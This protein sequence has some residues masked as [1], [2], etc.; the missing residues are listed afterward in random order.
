MGFLLGHTRSVQSDFG[1]ER[2]KKIH[3]KTTFYTLF[4]SQQNFT[5]SH[6]VDDLNAKH[7]QRDGQ[8]SSLLRHE[9]LNK[10][11]FE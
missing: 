10:I 1:S 5:N 2:T 6:L 3:Q 7:A 8:F 4:N 9:I 11:K